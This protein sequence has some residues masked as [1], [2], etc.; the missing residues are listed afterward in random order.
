ML[1]EEEGGRGGSQTTAD[2]RAS[3]AC[4]SWGCEGASRVTNTLQHCNFISQGFNY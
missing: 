2:L 3:Q 4:A 1:E